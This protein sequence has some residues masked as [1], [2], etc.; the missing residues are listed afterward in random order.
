MY[1][2]ITK[3]RYVILS[4]LLPLP[5]PRLWPHCREIVTFWPHGN[6]AL[7]YRACMHVYW[8]PVPG[9]LRVLSWLVTCRAGLFSLCCSKAAYAN[10]YSLALALACIFR[11]FR[12][13][14]WLGG[15][16]SLFHN[17]LPG[18]LDSPRARVAICNCIDNISV[19]SWNPTLPRDWDW[20]IH[21]RRNLVFS[22]AHAQQ[23]G[24]VLGFRWLILT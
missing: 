1:N 21:S 11:L 22:C 4:C 7:R 14:H 16:S 19:E 17:L 6:M 15:G 9:L 18:F 10:H 3:W 8:F 5:G 2:C 13:I 20:R 12:Y 23:P 24:S